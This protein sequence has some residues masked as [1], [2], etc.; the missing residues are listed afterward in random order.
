MGLAKA[1]VGAA[2][3]FAVGSFFVSAE[4][5]AA[6]YGRLLF[7][8]LLLVHAVE[9]VV[10]LPRLRAARGSLAANVLQTLLFGMVHVRGLET[11]R[12]GS[13]AV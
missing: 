4:S 11:Q 1:L 3:L 12:G 8:L 5:T 2:W 13:A 6:G 10:F 7:W 9:C